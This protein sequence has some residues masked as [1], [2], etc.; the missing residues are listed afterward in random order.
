MVELVDI[1]QLRDG[2]PCIV[3]EFVEKGSLM[4]LLLGDSLAGGAQTML[5]PEHIKNL[6]Y[7]MLS[8]LHYL[9][10]N[11]ILHRDLKPDNLM[12]AADG[13]LKFIDFGMARSYGQEVPLS[14]N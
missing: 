3:I 14:Q 10:S 5:R 6:A 9:H 13:T 4:N 1:F 11:F 12:L 2:S 8:G 7:Q